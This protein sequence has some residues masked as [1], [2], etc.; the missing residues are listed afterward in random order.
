MSMAIDDSTSPRQ[1]KGG[2][3]SMAAIGGS[4]GPWLIG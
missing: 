1:R 3:M 2:R 4:T